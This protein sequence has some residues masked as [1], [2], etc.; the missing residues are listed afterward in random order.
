MAVLAFHDTDTKFHFS[1]NN[2]HP[3]RLKRLLSNL[4]DAGYCPV[5]LDRYLRQPD[6]AVLVGLSFDDGFESFYRLAMPPLIDMGITATVFVPFD[7]VGR[8]ASWDYTHFLRQVRHMNREQI[9]E[10]S[11]SG[12]EIGSHG[13]SHSDLTGVP[14]RL[15]R[16]ELERS[17]KGLEDMIGKPIRFVSYPFGRFNAAVESMALEAG[18]DRGFSLSSFRKSRHQF[19]ISRL[20]VYSTDTTYS[21][22]KKI[23]GGALG[24][25]EKL[26]GAII[27]S[28]ARGT[29]LLNK[30]RKPPSGISG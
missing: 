4:K 21:V 11:E 3:A 28:Y 26:K 15:V 16:I 8:S 9:I 23:E 18:Y 7:F 12:I 13:C 19:T 10:A 1:L 30:F 6:N 29:I 5:S 22:L 24:R 17:K 2:Y 14:E 27:N 20:A 25:L